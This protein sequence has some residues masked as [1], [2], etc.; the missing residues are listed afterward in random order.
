MQHGATA[1]PANQDAIWVRSHQL[2]GVAHDANVFQNGDMVIHQTQHALDGV[3]KVKVAVVCGE[4]IY[5]T[6]P[7]QVI[8]VFVSQLGML[9]QRP[10]RFLKGPPI[11]PL[12]W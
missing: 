11:V 12:S 1:K 9:G 10:T 8:L 7:L 5:D 4:L 2:G 3:F 6:D